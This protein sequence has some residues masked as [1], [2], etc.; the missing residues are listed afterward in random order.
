MRQSVATVSGVFLAPGISKNGRYYSPSVIADAVARMQE[1][2]D[3]PAARPISVLD[4]HA[5]GDDSSRIA[6]RITK[7]GL[8]PDGAATFEAA[9]ADTPTGT[10]IASLTANGYLK[11]VSIRGWWL[12][13][14]RTET[15][16][17]RQ[18]ET[19]DSLEVDGVDC[20]K[21]PGVEAARILATTLAETGGH[22]PITETVENVTVTETAPAVTYADPGYLQATKRYP[23]GSPAQVRAAWGAVHTAEGYTPAQTKRI[24]GRIKAAAKTLGIGVAEEAS[25]LAASVTEALEEAWATMSLDNGPGEIRVSGYSNDPT[26]LPAVGR[27]V[28]LAAMA[29]LIALDPDNDGDIDTGDDT[30]VSPTECPFCSADVPSGAAFCPACGAPVTS[31]ST[32]PKEAPVTETA[33]TTSTATETTATATETKATETAPAAPA[34][35]ETTPVVPAVPVATTETAPA[36]NLTDADIAALAEALTPTVNTLTA[37][38]AGTPVVPVTTETAP[39]PVVEKTLPELVE[40]ALDRRIAETRIG[41]G[42]VRKGLVAASE[43]T[44][45]APHEMTDEEWKAHRSQ[46]WADILP[47]SR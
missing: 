27:R 33:S 37:A 8:R 35:T 1:R 30:A 2:L 44:E 34:A 43:T 18:A 38:R 12:G 40:E 10:T 6:G 5:A 23:L 21:S 36:R 41:G 39:A 17:G 29:G 25:V 20:T 22:T 4:H 3:D 14:V 7:V 24:K 13:P 11:N 9:L 45:K 26:D 46:A 28:A 31:E 42:F 16:N 19:A 32:T 15:I 47:T